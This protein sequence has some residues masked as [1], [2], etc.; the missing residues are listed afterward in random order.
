MEAASRASKTYRLGK[1][2]DPQIDFA[3]GSLTIRQGSDIMRRL[4]GILVSMLIWS[5]PWALAGLAVGLAL[6]GMD[7]N[8]SP[9][10]GW[11]GV[12]GLLAMIGAA[13]GAAN[14]LVFALFVLAAERNRTVETLRVGRI[15]L[16]GALASGGIAAFLFGSTVVALGTAAL[17]FGAAAS[18]AYVARRSAR[19]AVRG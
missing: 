12:P 13:V 15:G 5:V 10:P 11:L 6:A 17:G 2:G 16:W 9:D 3:L 4:R 18:M 19:R 1:S 14:G 7:L 8:V